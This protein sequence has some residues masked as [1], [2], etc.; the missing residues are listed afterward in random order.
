MRSNSAISD[1]R[2]CGQSCT[3]EDNEQMMCVMPDRTMRLSI[4]YLV[5]SA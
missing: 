5:S 4:Y 2:C 3:W 1:I